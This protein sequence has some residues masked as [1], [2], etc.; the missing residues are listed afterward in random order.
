MTPA[1]ETL[2]RLA[3]TDPGDLGTRARVAVIDEGM[4]MA[5]AALGASAR[6]KA[7]RTNHWRE[8]V[9][10]FRNSRA[11]WVEMRDIGSA[12]AAE[13]LAAPDRLAREIDRCETALAALR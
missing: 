6:L 3:R 10:R 8:A 5:H 11:F 7:E 9:R 1:S 2:T 13:E 12:V 4:G